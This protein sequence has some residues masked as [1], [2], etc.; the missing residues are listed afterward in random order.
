MGKPGQTVKASA[1]VVAGKFFARLFDLVLLLILSHILSPT[2]FGLIAL[3]MAPIFIGEAVLELPLVQAL[4]R[5]NNPPD[6]MYDTAFT[7]SVMRGVVLGALFIGLSWP[8]SKFY[9]EPRLTLLICALAVAP[10]LRGTRSPRLVIYMKKMDFRREFALDIF[11]KSTAFIIATTLAITT[12]SYWAIAA[13]TIISPLAM[14]ILSYFLAP[15][16]PRFTLSEWKHFADMIGWNSLSQIIAAINWQLD[17]LLLGRFVPQA[18]LGRYALANDLIAI[19]NQAVI[20]PLSRPLMANFTLAKTKIDLVDS[21]CLTLSAIF[22]LLAPV[23]LTLSLLA[24][25][26]VLVILGEKWLSAAQIIQWLAAISIFTLPGAALAPLALSLDRT[27]FM[28]L[29]TGI[30]FVVIVPS[31]IFGIMHY[32]IWGAI[33]ARGVAT[34]VTFAA[35]L[36]IVRRL[37]DLPIRSQIAPLLR[38]IIGIT[39]MA[40]TIWIC[41]PTLSA[42]SNTDKYSL[43]LD[44]IQCGLISG[45]VYLLAIYILWVM[46]GRPN[47]VESNVVRFVSRFRK[48]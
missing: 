6:A 28:T 38:G 16:K 20:A 37:I 42:Q 2:D 22:L 18:N 41:R 5:V 44:I 34:A 25:P 15:Y 7:L 13:A 36:F 10:I 40:G 45:I 46:S 32:G 33:A 21:Y 12:K 11:G 3:A 43:F 31:M 30:E 14:N 23:L 27:R 48:V 4:L 1:W 8:L 35:T 17:R 24:E 9:S 26:L 29:R 47:G 19:P 39:C